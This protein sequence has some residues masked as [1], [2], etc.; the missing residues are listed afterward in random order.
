MFVVRQ[1]VSGEPDTRRERRMAGVRR[2]DP[3]SEPDR[4][5][6]QVELAG[7]EQPDDG[8]RQNKD[9]VQVYQHG[10]MRLRK[11]IDENPSAARLWAFLAENI[12]GSC[13]AV[14]VAQE[15]LAEQLGVTDRTIR[16]LTTWLENQNALVRI[17]VG[18]TVYAYAL[19]PQDVW[20]SWD[21]T[22]ATAAFNTRTLVK[23]GDAQNATVKRRLRMMLREQGVEVPDEDSPKQDEA[24]KG[25]R[26][27]A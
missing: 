13:G 1:S 12:D 27:P 2:V 9:F 7:L 3:A 15:V 19:D 18:G 21:K 8:S 17:R 11:L 16:R 20:K 22:K 5:L 24:S 25:E 6:R 23:K 4:K 26:A 14:V 10:W